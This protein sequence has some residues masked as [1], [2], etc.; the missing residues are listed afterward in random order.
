MA[1]S[2][3]TQETIVKD[4]KSIKPEQAVLEI[5]TN[6]IDAWA[7]LININF[8]QD[9]VS[10][11]GS[12]SFQ[13]NGEWIEYDNIKNMFWSYKHSTKPHR[14]QNTPSQY[15]WKRGIW[16]YTFSKIWSK[17]VWQ[18]VFKKWDKNYS[19]TISMDQSILR[20]YTYDEDAYPS[21]TES[22]TGTLLTISNID[23]NIISNDFIQKSVIPLILRQEGWRII[24]LWVKI[25]VNDNEIDIKEAI[26]KEESKTIRKWGKDFSIRI[27]KWKQ[28]ISWED[29]QFYFIDSQ[30]IEKYKEHTW[31]NRWSDGF[32]HSVFVKSDF[33]DNFLFW[34]W[35][36]IQ[37]N[38]SKTFKKLKREVKKILVDFRRS[39]LKPQAEAFTEKLVQDWVITTW[40]S[41]P[42]QE[43]SSQFI[44]DTIQELYMCE[45]KIVNSLSKEQK[46]IFFRLLG[47]IAEKWWEDKL[48]EIIDHVLN[49]TEEE[50]E[51]FAEI[52]KDVS[53][54][55]IIKTI[56][57]IEDRLKVLSVLEQ[58][59][60]KP[61][62][63]ANE[64]DDL[65]WLISQHYWIFWEGYALYA[66]EEED[67]KKIVVKIR[68]E[69]FEDGVQRKDLSFEWED[70]EL[71]IFMCKTLRSTTTEWIINV[72]NVV[73]ELKHPTKILGDKEKR[74]VEGYMQ[75]FS[76]DPKLNWE[77]F[78]W[79]YILVG[80]SI[81][82]NSLI[83]GAIESAS[84]W[85]EK[86][87]WLIQNNKNMKI[88]VRKWCDI[89]AECRSKMQYL[90]EAL[91]LRY[92]R[93]KAQ[94]QVSTL[95][96][97]DAILDN[98]AVAVL[99]QVE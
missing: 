15:C 80:T 61:E 78:S 5:I 51:R 4:I 69:V 48:L 24:L 23:S 68:N 88:Y 70:K 85:W 45:P 31:L 96:E 58:Y 16:R 57:I 26:E 40:G 44:Q 17:A 53:L 87:F 43:Y 73:V 10:G 12:I 74:Q 8:T 89:I 67:I 65:Q 33:F 18:T 81:N 60:E 20:D 97:A 32:G 66:N 11:I 19:Y 13:D 42:I 62:I 22:G 55:N 34:N 75:A 56:T 37:E 35:E 14:P 95:E 1:T 36:I 83:P 3:V 29:S 71:D 86:K 46:K 49:L 25:L 77:F 90:Y 82:E 63:W 41:S 9:D 84:N 47:T 6:A 64:K 52:L 91:N 98:S 59:L 27:V 21:E 93:I 94:S 28:P 76:K 79:K 99:P 2:E 7:K 72:D 30:R 54:K 50:K 38:E 92:D 39:F